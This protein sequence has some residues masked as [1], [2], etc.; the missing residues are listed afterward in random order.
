MHPGKGPG[1]GLAS[2]QGALE[3]NTGDPQ[4]VRIQWAVTGGLYVCVNRL[5]ALNMRG[6]CVDKGMVHFSRLPTG[7]KNITSEYSDMQT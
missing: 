7:Q 5:W 2:A 6:P 3:P 1:K 4:S